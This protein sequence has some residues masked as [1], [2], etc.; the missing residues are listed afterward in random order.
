MRARIILA[1]A[2]GKHNSQIARQLD[3]CLDTVRHWR[4]RWI[5]LQAASLDDLPVKERRL[6]C[7]SPRTACPDDGRANLEDW[8]H[9]Q[10][11]KPKNA[12]SADFAGREIA[13]ARH[14]PRHGGPDFAAPCRWLVK[15]ND[16]QP[17]LIRSWLRPPEDAHRQETVKAMCTLYEQAPAL[18]EQGEQTG[19]H[20]EMT[21]FVYLPCPKWRSN[22]S[23]RSRYP[24]SSFRD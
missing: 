8:W 7:P 12:P 16:L 9:W 20:D 10:A 24:G 15:N 1:A 5:G 18:A 13:E 17:H 3:V 22:T 4:T 11:R 2:E 21:G 14:A 19:S 6:R 23:Y